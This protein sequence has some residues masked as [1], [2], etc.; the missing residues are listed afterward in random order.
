MVLKKADY[1]LNKDSAMSCL[2]T[3]RYTVYPLIQN[4]KYT[5]ANFVSNITWSLAENWV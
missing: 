5:H 2:Y 1:C 3:C 4:N